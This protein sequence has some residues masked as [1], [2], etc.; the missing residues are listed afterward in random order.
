MSA[1]PQKKFYA[2]NMFDVVDLEK[3]GL[4]HYDAVVDGEPPASRDRACRAM[5]GRDG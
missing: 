1:S 4:G 2:L 5:S 3:R